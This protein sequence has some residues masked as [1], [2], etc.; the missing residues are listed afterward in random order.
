M[1]VL[2]VGLE[3]W[4]LVRAAQDQVHQEGMLVLGDRGQSKA[5]PLLSVIRDQRAQFLAAL[6]ALRLDVG[7]EEKRGPGSPTQWEL[8]Q[9]RMGR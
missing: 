6:K 7:A 4:D 2:E 3:A 9:K 8:A 5:H 1:A